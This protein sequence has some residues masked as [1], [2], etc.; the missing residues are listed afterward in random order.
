[1]WRFSSRPWIRTSARSPVAVL[2]VADP[3]A[4]V[5]E[6]AHGP[7]QSSQARLGSEGST[8]VRSQ[9]RDARSGPSTARVAGARLS[10]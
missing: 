9:G 6:L 2:V 7:M 1:M 3:V 8:R 4:L 5:S 10:A